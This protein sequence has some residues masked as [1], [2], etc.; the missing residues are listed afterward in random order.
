M[1][2]ETEQ[3]PTGAPPP[4][5]DELRERLEQELRRLTVSDVVVQ[6]ALTVSSLGYQR[7]AGDARDLEQARLAIESLRALVPVLKGA[8]PEELTKS[9]EQTV[10]NMQLAYA[11]AV[12]GG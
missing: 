5:E 6:A 1:A 8:A 2:E 12:A 11:K 4:S 7:L 3:Q 10:A 9:L